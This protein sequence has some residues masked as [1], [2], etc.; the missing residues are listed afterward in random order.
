MRNGFKDTMGLA[1]R[2]IAAMQRGMLLMAFAASISH[3]QTPDLY[4]LP[5]TSHAPVP[6]K[7]V[8]RKWASV[9]VAAPVQLAS[10]EEELVPIPR[11]EP[12][13]DVDLQG[14]TDN[15]SLVATEAS[16]PKVLQMIAEHHGF[17]LVLGPDV[18]GPV[19]VSIRSARMDEVLDAILG[20]SGFRWHRHGNLLYVTSMANSENLGREVQGRTLRVFPL[21]FISAADVE[22]VATGLLTT[23]GKVYISESDAID[24]KKTREL[25]VVEDIPEAVERV[26]EYLAQ[27]DQPPRQVLIESHIL[28]IALGDEQKHGINLRS[29]ARIHNSEVSVTTKGLADET[30]PK[31]LAFRVDGNDLGGILELIRTETNSRTLASPKLTVVN[32]QEAKIQIGQRLSYNVATTT[33]TSTIQSVQFLEVG[34]VLTVQPTIA[35]DGQIL[36]SVLPKVSGGRINQSSGLPEEDTTQ[37]STTVLLPDGGGMI[38]G[39]LIKDETLADTSSIPGISRVPWVGRLFRRKVDN[40]RRNEIIV[41]M[42]A[43]IVP[44]VC[45][46]R[47]HELRELGTTLPDYAAESL[48]LPAPVGGQPSMG[49][50][51]PEAVYYETDDQGEPYLGTEYQDTG[52]Q[53]AQ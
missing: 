46:I 35:E 12:S 25:L 16:L 14:D 24:T 4:P 50:A 17:N 6:V 11:P 41:A 51:Y 20:V 49:A 34:I 1:M 29:L 22:G 18:A 36:M 21:N 40:V 26:A 37:V 8:P 28:Q 19:T 9:P 27:I 48:T 2:P 15:V 13:E 5:E 52:Y 7:R 33:Q 38:I 23:A 44:D 30:V 47:P 39:G 45:S 10:A 42:V 31:G 53:R 43:H 32:N 3:A